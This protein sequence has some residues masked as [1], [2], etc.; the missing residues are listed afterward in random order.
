[1]KVIPDAAAAAPTND[2]RP[3]AVTAAAAERAPELAAP[4]PELKAPPPN[5][6]LM[7]STP[8]P[9]PVPALTP[10]PPAAA[11]AVQSALATPASVGPAEATSA[12]KPTKKAPPEIAHEPGER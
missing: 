12:S 6:G 7:G 9:T 3:T 4:A 2:A 5:L 11:H 10:P 8:G 1:M